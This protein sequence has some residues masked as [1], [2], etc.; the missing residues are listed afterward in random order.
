M[1]YLT[2]TPDS[3]STVFSATKY[4]E[5]NSIKCLHLIAST[6]FIDR[7]LVISYYDLIANIRIL[8]LKRIAIYYIL[9]QEQ[10]QIDEQYESFNNENLEVCYVSYNH[11][12]NMITSPDFNF[13][14]NNRC[15]L[16]IFYGVS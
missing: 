16:F 15:S 4:T 12:T 8:N 1:K 7:N 6:Y 13:D 11:F 3:I 5:I 9:K 10:E 14:F 2:I